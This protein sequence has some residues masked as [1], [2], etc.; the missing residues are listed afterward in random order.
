MTETIVEALL[1][2]ARAGDLE[3]YA[4][5]I[6]AVPVYQLSTIG[7]LDG[8]QQSVAALVPLA[9]GGDKLRRLKA[10][11]LIGRADNTTQQ[12]QEALARSARDAVRAPP[13]QFGVEGQKA[14][15]PDERYY[16]SLVV[17]RSEADW[18]PAYAAR[19]LVDEEGPPRLK[20]DVRAAFAS[21]VFDRMETL[22]EAFRLM[23][24]AVPG[25]LLEDPRTKDAELSRT[26]R[27]AR[28]LPAIEH[29]TRLAM[30]DNGAD[31][32]AG[33]NEMLQ[34]L[35]FRYGRPT[36]G[37]EGDDLAAGVVDAAL[38]L[39]STLLRT[40]F[41]I[42]VETEAYKTV[43]RLK[44]WHKT[45]SWPKAARGARLR[46]EQTLLQAIVL[47]ARTGNA[48]GELLA[49]LIQLAGDRRR[50]ERQLAADAETPGIPADVQDWMRAGGRQSAPRF[51]TAAAGEAGLRDVDTLIAGATLRAHH[52]HGLAEGRAKEAVAMIR[53]KL[54]SADA[55]RAL[56]QF[57]NH[58]RALANDVL[59]LS[60]RRS[61][62]TF[63][64]PGALVEAV[65]SRHQLEDAALITTEMVQ[66]ERPGIERL[67]PN[68]TAEVILPAIVKGAPGKRK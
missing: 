67:L 20:N 63:G 33:F 24:G 40:R 3:G 66:I 62:A 25:S 16:I 58:S 35:V 42:S 17:A 50:V 45:D 18:V 26:R 31:L 11:A 23:A 56:V 51:R 4:E 12:K 9:A 8:F 6:T 57:L 47:R 21:L 60:R 65:P 1:D 34:A 32:A 48:S 10:L 61:F 55:V 30:S 14:L 15:S 53:Q 5:A 59:A 68:G 46:L 49:V 43:G 64:E 27:L 44:H 39:L 2:R 13:P 7:N 19:A 54:D 52:L 41:L 37:T 28:L 38:M 36:T 22:T 29:A